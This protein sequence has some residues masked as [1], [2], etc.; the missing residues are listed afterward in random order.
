MD[1]WVHFV[2]PYVDLEGNPIKRTPQTHPYN[3]DSF[4]TWMGGDRKDATGAIYSDRLFQWD[5]DKHD[6]L[7]QKHFG[8]RGQYWDKRDPKEIE[9][10]LRDWTDNQS[11]R[12][13]YVVQCCNQASGY[14]CWCFGY[15]DK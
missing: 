12:L 10:F 1:G 7:C 15:A 2:H 11:L 4:V 6:R 13:I 9:A 14:P 3:Y 5:S 8:N